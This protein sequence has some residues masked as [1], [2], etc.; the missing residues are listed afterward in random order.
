MVNEVI[1][2]AARKA[3]ES[4]YDDVCSIIEYSS[5]TD[6]KSKIT[7]QSEVTVLENQP[8]RLSFEKLAA[9]VQTDTV[10]KISQGL[11][12]F[13]APEIVVNAGSKIVVTTAEGRTEEYSKS[14]VAAVYPTHQEIM[15][16]LFKGWA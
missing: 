5:V 15:L 16:E 14:G 8:C 9:A 4:L 6:E 2:K 10:A 13:L 12:L 11:K 7:R 3:Q 1:Q